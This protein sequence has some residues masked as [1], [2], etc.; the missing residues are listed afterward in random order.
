VCVTYDVR[1]LTKWLEFKIL[2]SFM[3]AGSDTRNF[4]E[5]EGDFL[6]MQDGSDA[7]SA[8]RSV[9]FENH[10]FEVVI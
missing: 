5:L 2:R 4:D 9:E 7:T 1:N 6:L 8:G 10:C 3:L